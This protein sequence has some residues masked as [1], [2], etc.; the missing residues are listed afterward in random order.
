MSSEIGG[1]DAPVE[2]AD[3]HWYRRV[4]TF[5]SLESRDYRYLLA[6]NIFSNMA[7]WLQLITL[8]WLVWELTKDPDTD[9]GSALLSGTAAGM[10]AFPTLIIGPWAGV[11]ADRMDRKRLVMVAQAFLGVVAVL[12]ALLIALDYDR[13]EVWHV[14]LYAA[15]SA[16]SN[17][18]IQPARMALVANTVPR[19]DLGNA[20]ALN[21]M[22]VT[23]MR[24][25]GASVGGVLITTVGIEWNFFVEG[26]AAVLMALL[27]VP[28]KTP[29]QEPSTA[30]E[31]SMLTNLRDGVSYIWVENR[32]ILHLMILSFILALVFMPLP[33][34]LPAYTDGVLDA[35]ADV[36]GYLMATMGAGGFT[37]T[38]IIA[39]FGFPIGTGRSGLLALVV[40]SSAILVMAQSNWI[41]LSLV[42]VT[43]MGFAQTFFIVGNMTLIQTMVPDTLRG[44]VSSIW[45]L[46]HALNPLA[47]V[48]T[49]LF[50]DLYTASM[51]WTI[52]ASTS[53]V[54]AVY[55]LFTF[56]QVRRLR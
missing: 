35:D 46:Q 8:S 7:M 40:G 48:L 45:S 47:I 19:K 12:F 50:I 44:R 24:L 14:F 51:A 49:G 34:L 20:L 31:S 27:L 39:S 33:A 1:P 23:G 2:I 52:I 36:G 28:M 41:F 4:R 5:A 21:A 32:V 13:L 9:K 29:Y 16:V 11:V 55:F 15:V 22:S 3:S 42:M 53:L 6:G 10:R 17:A 25:A 18:V 26:G 43:F 56:R 54:L 38:L 30:Q 37:A